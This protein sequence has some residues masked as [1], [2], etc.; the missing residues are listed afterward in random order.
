MIKFLCAVRVSGMAQ[1]RRSPQN[2]QITISLEKELV[3]KIDLAAAED[4]RARSNFIVHVIKQYI[5]AH[6]ANIYPVHREE[7]SHAADETGPDYKIKKR[8][9]G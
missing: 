1:K 8:K 9:T 7:V 6:A 3:E 2:T 4:D 5:E